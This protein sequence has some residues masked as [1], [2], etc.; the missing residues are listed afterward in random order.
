[1]RS[2]HHMLKKMSAVYFLIAG[3]DLLAQQ[4]TIDYKKL[5]VAL[6]IVKLC[7]V[8]SGSPNKD[9]GCVDS[10]RQ[11]HD[12]CVERRLTSFYE[13]P[14][15]LEMNRAVKYCPSVDNSFYHLR[16]FFALDEKNCV[17][18]FETIPAR[19][20]SFHRNVSL[21]DLEEPFNY[22]FEK[23][24]CK[25]F[26]RYVNLCEY[27]DGD[28]KKK[29]A[30]NGD[31]LPNL[32]KFLSKEKTCVPE[33]NSSADHSLHKVDHLL[34]DYFNKNET[35]VY[36]RAILKLRTPSSVSNSSPNDCEQIRGSY[37]NLG[38]KKWESV[39]ESDPIYLENAKFQERRLQKL[40]AGSANGTN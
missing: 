35:E 31:K 13:K 10:L 6:G 32:T 11:L 5:D 33:S 38:C 40:D 36:G 8:K 3:S 22:D 34:S 4:A 7:L 2:L 1:M 26:K 24:Q 9:L 39:S 27:V 25:E 18:G 14:S 15:V 17:K 29:A 37:S 28:L 23:S 12:Y 20:R 16:D 21:T 19:L 30:P